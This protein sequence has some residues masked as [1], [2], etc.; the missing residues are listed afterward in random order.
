MYRMFQDGSPLRACS[1]CT[2]EHRKSQESTSRV[3]YLIAD[4]AR[5]LSVLIVNQQMPTVIVSLHDVA[6][7]Y[8]VIVLDC[9]VLKVYLATKS[10]H[11]SK[12]SAMSVTIST[13]IVEDVWN[14][15]V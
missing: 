12:Q 15:C 4:A 8:Q 11:L 7:V 3:V 5:N 14:K 9:S 10:L 2:T 13:Y 1:N 6:P